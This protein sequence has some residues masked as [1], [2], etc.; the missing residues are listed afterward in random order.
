MRM[1]RFGPILARFC[2]GP[3]NFPVLVSVPAST[4]QV[5]AN[6]HD[7]Y[8]RPFPTTNLHGRCS[9][10][11]PQ[12]ATSDAQDTLKTRFGENA[13]RVSVFVDRLVDMLGSGKPCHAWLQS[14]SFLVQR[15]EHAKKTS[16]P[17]PFQT[18][19]AALQQLFL[20]QSLIGMYL[21]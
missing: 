11:F 15:S 2:S 1:A 18:R 14:R 6:L 9:R 10:L 12:Q 7:Q 13:Q 19:H 4:L 21:T 16:I 17:C 8:A 5:Y 20:L 3:S